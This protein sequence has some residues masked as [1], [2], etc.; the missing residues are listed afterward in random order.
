MIETK[1]KRQEMGNKNCES[2]KKS[3]AQDRVSINSTVRL[4]VAGNENIESL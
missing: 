2:T 3:C 1:N 4:H